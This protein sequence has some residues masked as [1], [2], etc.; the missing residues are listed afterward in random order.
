MDMDLRSP[1]GLL[2]HQGSVLDVMLCWCCLEIPNNICTRSPIFPF[3]T[4]SA[5]YAASPMYGALLA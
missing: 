4:K 1:T 5:D 3:Y 2:A